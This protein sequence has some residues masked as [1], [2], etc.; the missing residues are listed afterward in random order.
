[1]DANNA[2]DGFRLVLAST[3]PRRRELLA[4]LGH[5]FEAID[6][7]LDDADLASG[8]PDLAQWV[9]SLSY[10]KAV[11]GARQIIAR[12]E[13]FHGLVIVGADTLV[14]VD[15]RVLSKARS[16]DEAAEMI[17]LVRGRAHDVLTGVT[18]LA[19][20]S[21]RR[22]IFTDR[23]TV[24]VGTISDEM[25]SAY[26]ATDG[27]RGKSGAYNLDERLS[28]GWPM[29]VVGDPTTVT[30]LPIDRLRGRLARFVASLPGTTALREVPA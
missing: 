17:R 7:G 5:P 4:R 2:K 15:G 16:A 28:A 9:A 27:W 12:G 14:E 18:L 20:F 26:T 29:R 1:M 13:H 6:P 22:D 19:P 11:A 23:V 24:H 30:G 8:T 21:G 25:I 10:L 3:S